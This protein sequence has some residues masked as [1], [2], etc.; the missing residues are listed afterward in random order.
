MTPTLTGKA[1]L[2]PVITLAEKIKEL[3]WAT[4]QNM[5]R[6]ERHSKMLAE[7]DL[8]GTEEENRFMRRDILNRLLDKAE[9]TKETRGNLLAAIARIEMAGDLVNGIII[10]RTQ[11]LAVTFKK[12]PLK[13]KIP[14]RIDEIEELE[15]AAENDPENRA[16][17]L[18]LRRLLQTTVDELEEGPKSFFGQVL[19]GL[20]KSLQKASD[21]RKIARAR[22]LLEENLGVENAPLPEPATWLGPE[23]TRTRLKIE[24]TIALL[25]PAKKVA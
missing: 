21:E 16:K 24:S 10:R 23:L 19:S 15:K 4:A 3:L 25:C 9:V 11:A 12:S 20:Q 7:I 5:Q 1:A 13:G 14:Q 8:E 2:I 18:A 17:V 22:Q 6:S